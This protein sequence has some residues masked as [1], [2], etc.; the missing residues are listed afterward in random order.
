MQVGQSIT[1]INPA[2]RTTPF[3]TVPR[4]ISYEIAAV[5]EVGVYDYD[6][7]FVVMPIEDAQILMLLDD[8]IGMIEIKTIDPDNVNQIVAPLLPKIANKGI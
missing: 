5:F 1:I 3:G 2:G 6:K 7:A 8:Q 4:E